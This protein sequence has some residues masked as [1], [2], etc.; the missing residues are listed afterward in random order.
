[1]DENLSNKSS[2]DEI[3][4][5][6]LLTLIKKGINRVGNFFLRLFIYIK[7]NSI[8]L[9]GLIILGVAASFALKT[10]VSQ[11]MKTE[12]IVRPN[13]ESKNYL[14]DAINEIE[15]N[16]ISENQ[17][18]AESLNLE[19]EDFKGFHIA[20]EAIE[21]EEIKSED[22][23][24]EETKY[25]EVLQNFKDESF[26]V[27]ILKSE[28]SEK[29]IIDH[30]I[31]FQYE[32]LVS[33]QEVVKVLMNYINSNDY[34]EGLKKVY[35]ENA[36]SRIVENEK[37]ITQIDG[38]VANY[39]K[40]LVSDSNKQDAGMVYMEKE[41]LNVPS[42]LNM[43]NKLSKKIEEKKLELAEQNEVV[44]ILNMGNPQKVI[45]PFFSRNFVL[46]PLLL[47]LAF[48]LFSLFKYVNNK[49]KEL[50]NLND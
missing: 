26:V 50:Q 1:M 23:L 8:K 39:S 2:A 9:A 18:F 16:I 11:K 43:K 36:E 27:D 33:G 19:L 14:Y 48:F 7:K 42:L 32:D 6:Q 45:K 24:A 30:K 21:D 47:L 4:L 20:I 25:L 28:L 29:S 41:N 40:A 12:V 34:F 22:I 35:R 10:I 5:R 49:S 17:E 15:V 37:L 13:F 46:I 44:S 3:D 31:T 38:L